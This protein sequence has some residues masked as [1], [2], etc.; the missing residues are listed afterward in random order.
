MA[1]KT[2]LGS[3]N[4]RA[5]PEAQPYE[6]Q[7]TQERQRHTTC[8]HEAICVAG[9]PP[10]GKQSKCAHT[11][12]VQGVQQRAFHQPDAQVQQV[13]WVLPVQQNVQFSDVLISYHQLRYIQT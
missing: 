11:G 6:T 7:V 4:K 1:H 3:S 8:E 2:G 10:R 9:Q 13:T 12:R 5:Y